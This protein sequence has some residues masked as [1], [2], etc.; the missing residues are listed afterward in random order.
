MTSLRRRHGHHVDFLLLLSDFLAKRSSGKVKMMVSAVR[1][2]QNTCVCEDDAESEH[3]SA[4]VPC[5]R[6]N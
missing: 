6:W 5:E 3:G 2:V 1:A 4:V